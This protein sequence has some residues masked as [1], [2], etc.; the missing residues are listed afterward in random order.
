MKKCNIFVCEN[1]APEFLISAKKT[2]SDDIAIRPY[3]S[4]C[5]IK[6][7][8][9]VVERILRESAADGDVGII[10]C[11]KNCDIQNINSAGSPFEIHASPYC[12]SY[13]A[14]EETIESFIEEGAYMLSTGWLG[15]WREKI[16]GAGFDR[17][18]ARR[19]YREFCKKLVFFDTGIDDE[20]M[21]NI[22]ELSEYLGLPYV[23]VPVDM[24]VYDDFL[25]KIYMDWKLKVK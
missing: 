24:G 5:M 12:G 6:S 20:S 21:K 2:G 19:F 4:M 15:H 3:P 23:V 16:A 14:D 13:L 7:N 22:N 11:G 9:A 8:K 10:L 1:F 17:D 25:K 18:T